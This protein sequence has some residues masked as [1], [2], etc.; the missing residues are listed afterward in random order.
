MNNLF[1]KPE[2]LKMLTDIFMEYCPSAEIW[3]YGSRLNG[4][5]HDGSDLDLTVKT[6]NSDNKDLSVLKGLLSESNIPFIVD[7]NEFDKLPQTFQN[8]IKKGYLVIFGGK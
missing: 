3:A 1:I 8:E 6:F 5:A 4:G 7:I 2:H